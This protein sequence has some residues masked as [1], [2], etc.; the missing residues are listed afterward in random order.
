MCGRSTVWWQITPPPLPR[1]VGLE[2]LVALP[3]LRTACG[4]GYGL[5]ACSDLGVL[6][7]SNYVDNTLSVFT[8]S[9]SG[10]GAGA[11]EAAAESAGSC[12]CCRQQHEEGKEER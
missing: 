10:A 1:G 5:A 3:A 7:T 11:W 9:T 8:L 2:G 12:S 6:V 4:R